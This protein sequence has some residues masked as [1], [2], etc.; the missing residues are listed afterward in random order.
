MRDKKIHFQLLTRWLNFYF[1]TFE[2]L[3]RISKIKSFT[4]RW[5]NDSNDIWL[6][7]LNGIWLNEIRPVW[8]N[9]WV[10]LYE[11]SGCGF[12][13]HCCH[14]NFRYH[15][16]FK[17]RIPWHSGNYRAWIHSETPTWHDNNIQS[18]AFLQI[19]AHSIAQSFGQFD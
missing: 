17:Q 1:S 16:C 19:S 7:G 10:F 15:T 2:L 12:E 9:G 13:S 14:L 18:N 4:T 6:N 8:L 11:L 5:S 3:T